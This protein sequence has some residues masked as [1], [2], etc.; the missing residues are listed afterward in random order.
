MQTTTLIILRWLYRMVKSI[1]K[2]IGRLFS[3]IRQWWQKRKKEKP[4]QKATD[5]ASRSNLDDD[6][7]YE[8]YAEKIGLLDDV[9]VKLGLHKRVSASHKYMYEMGRRDGSLGVVLTNLADIAKA[10]A[11]E[12]FRHIYVILKGSLASL[13]ADMDT[14]SEIM[15]YDQQ[16]HNREQAHY[17]YLKYQYR[18]FPRNYSWFL[19]GLYLV[20]AIA[21]ILADIPLALRLI[22]YG[23]YLPG[24]NIPGE[25]FSE[26][27]IS[28][29]FWTILAINWETT[30]T[31]LGIS[32]CTIYIKIYYDEF[33]GTPY[34]NK[35]MTFKR[36]VE[37][38]KLDG[39]L[40]NE[41]SIHADIKQEHRYK[42][43]WK[44]GLAIFTLLS[45][46]ALAVFRLKI[47]AKVEGFDPTFISAAAFIAITILFPIIGGI[48]LSHA[49]TNFQNM[50]RLGRAGRKCVRSRRVYLR[51]VEKY[52]IA[53]KKYEDIY[54]AD[55]RLCDE[56]RMVE[57]YKGYLIAFYTRGFS[58]G[59][60]QPE[61]Y[62]KGEDF[63]SKILEWRN[64]AI[65]RKINHNISKLN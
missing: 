5:Q 29:S 50:S 54:S 53:Q 2:G 1:L 51:S 63:Y 6:E 10:T 47:A 56:N 65:A 62:I 26:L 24:S 32:L 23:F 45:I 27:F 18:F 59:G 11:Q 36:F 20:I 19:F 34:A 55:Q 9:M 57:E 40:I 42:R 30:T 48:C 44:T 33:I 28:G 38:N 39:N 52:T 60:M 12:M 16:C 4:E 37:E 31:A 22:Q 58:T 7:S 49:L 17:D 35:I 14:R 41:D 25:T 64:I 3:T 8:Q 15:Q 13:K 43:R 61:K 21:L 46:L